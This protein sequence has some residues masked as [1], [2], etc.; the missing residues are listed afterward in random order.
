MVIYGD[1]TIYDAHCSRVDLT[2]GTPDGDIPRKV[3]VDFKT[4]APTV[5]H[6]EDLRFYALLETI[7]MGV[8]P[9][10]LASYYLDAARVEPEDVTPAV[11]EAALARTIDGTC[12][13]IEILR[14]QRAATVTPSVLCGWCSVRADC[15]EGAAHWAE[16]VES[17]R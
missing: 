11:L 14:A 2:L 8:P 6:R 13:L 15:S 7:R 10:T 4:G 12:R 17:L 1:L 3:I 9:R 5:H 16:Q